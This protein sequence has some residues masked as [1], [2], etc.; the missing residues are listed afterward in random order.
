MGVSFARPFRKSSGERGMVIWLE[1][2]VVL[3]ADYKQ[4]RDDTKLGV[5]TPLHFSFADQPHANKL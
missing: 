5:A 4:G 2:E 3:F 1:A